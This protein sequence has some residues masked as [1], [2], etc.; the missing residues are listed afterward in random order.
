MRKVTVL[1]YVLAMLLLAVLPALAQDTPPLPEVLANDPNGR[2]TTLLAAVEAVG[3]TETLSGEG[4]FTLLAPTN[5]AF[6]A[7][8]DYLGLEVD[9]L[10]ADTEMLTA[11]LT[12]HVLPERLFFRQL[13]GGPTVETVQGDTVTFNLTDG[14]FTVEGANIRDVDNVAS[15]GVM[16]VLNSVILPPAIRE[17]AAANRAHIRFAHFSPDAD[18]VDIYIAQQITDLTGVTFG[19][20]SEW[21][22]VASGAYSVGIAPTGLSVRRTELGRVAPGAWVTIAIVGQNTTLDL[23]ILFLVEDYSPMTEGQSRVSVLHAIQNDPGVDVLSNGTPV[24]INLNYPRAVGTND[25]FDMRTVDVGSVALA[26]NVTGTNTELLADT[27]LLEA[28][29]NYLIVAAG[30]PA[31]R[32][33]LVYSTNVAEVAG[34]AE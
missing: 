25:G 28:G 33:L 24:I 18:A 11:V 13:T 1:V 30:T 23:D 17:A 9:E 2:F 22:E 20:V 21:Q 34:A 8:L 32:Q 3:L 4:P 15:N 26:L 29:V 7:A 31:T 5:N 27:L 6:A 12:Y 19:T 14:V 10:L 16:H